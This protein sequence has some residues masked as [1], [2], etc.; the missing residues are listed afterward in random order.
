MTVFVVMKTNI[1]TFT[2]CNSYEDGYYDDYYDT[3]VESSELVG[4][5]MSIINAI[6]K[7]TEVENENVCCRVCWFPYIIGDEPDSDEDIMNFIKD[8]PDLDCFIGP[9]T[10]DNDAPT[11]DE[12]D[13][14]DMRLNKQ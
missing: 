3:E 6:K 7:A 13:W 12:L 10:L 9:Y 14:Y 8:N 11:E 5:Y 4:I 1:D 2:T